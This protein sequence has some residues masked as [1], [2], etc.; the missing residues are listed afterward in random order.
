MARRIP[1]SRQVPPRSAHS[2]RTLARIRKTRPLN[3]PRHERELHL[4]APLTE[5][6][7]IGVILTHLGEPTTPPPLA[8]RP[9]ADEPRAALPSRSNCA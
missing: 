3:Y 4:I 6:G 9:R 8:L 7:A 5:P 2:A 1:A